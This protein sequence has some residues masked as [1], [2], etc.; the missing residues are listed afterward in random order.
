VIHNYEEDV[1]KLTRIYF[2]RRGIPL[3]E[4]AQYV[5]RLGGGEIPI[6]QRFLMESIEALENEGRK[7]LTDHFK[8]LL[9]YALM[10]S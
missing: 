4:I 5:E 3:S 8:T 9:G 10:V 6:F 2:I 7:E 1:I